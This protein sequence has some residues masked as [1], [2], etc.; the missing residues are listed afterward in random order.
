MKR[1]IVLLNKRRKI[2]RRNWY[3]Q[4][5]GRQQKSSVGAEKLGVVRPQERGELRLIFISGAGA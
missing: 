3:Q 1:R 4:V 2:M 5:G